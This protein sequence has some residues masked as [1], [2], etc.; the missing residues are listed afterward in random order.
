M[1]A[2]VMSKVR[3]KTFTDYREDDR[4]AFAHVQNIMQG[5]VEG[6]TYTQPMSNVHN[7]VCVMNMGLFDH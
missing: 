3:S 7:A 2:M 1:F 6:L 4:N 5:D